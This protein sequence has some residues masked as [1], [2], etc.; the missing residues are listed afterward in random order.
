MKTEFRP[1][2]EATMAADIS[3]LLAMEAAGIGAWQWNFTAGSLRL[4]TAAPALIS[5]PCDPPHHG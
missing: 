2:P 4:S 1:M 3:P 5:P